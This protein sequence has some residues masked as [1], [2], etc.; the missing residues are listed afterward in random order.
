MGKK[1]KTKAQ[2]TKT[3]KMLPKSKVITYK[4]NRPVCMHYSDNFDI[5]NGYKVQ[6]SSNHINRNVE[7]EPDFGLYADYSW[8]P[9]WRNEYLNWADFG[10]PENL[11]ICFTQIS[12]A[13]DRVK[14]GE[15]VEVGCL[16]GHGRTG[17]VLSIMRVILGDHY[18]NAI[19]AVRSQ[20][21]KRAIESNLQE[22][23]IEFYWC[24]LNGVIAPEEPEDWFSD[25]LM[26][27]KYNSEPVSSSVI[28]PKTKRPYT[29]QYQDHIAALDQGWVSC[30][31]Y[32]SK[33]FHW[34]T[35]ERQ[36]ALNLE[37]KKNK[38]TA[39]DLLIKYNR[40]EK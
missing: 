23:L 37:Y 11:D 28:N 27:D 24:K 7:N 36:W 20:Y 25:Y 6:A 29:C 30:P 17:T 13:V 9:D 22:W 32:G 35:D 39:K 14:N 38:Q 3:T 40:K 15:R 34:D 33:C 8:R 4:I 5:G 1:K 26:G 21:C 31:N 16:G 2:K 12:S 10:I 18:F 19:K